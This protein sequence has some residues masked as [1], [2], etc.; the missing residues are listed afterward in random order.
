MSLL[1]VDY[2]RFKTSDG[3]ELYLAEF[4]LPFREHLNPEH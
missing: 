3:G 4:G 1:D 2:F